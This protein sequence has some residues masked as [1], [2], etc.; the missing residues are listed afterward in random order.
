[1]Q[2]GMIWLLR[3]KEISKGFQQPDGTTLQVLKD[4]SFD[5]GD[6]QIMGLMGANGSGKTTLL[7]VISGE[8]AADGGGI[9]V[10]G[11]AIDALAAYRRYRF[12]GRVHQESY[13]AMAADLTVAQ[14][15]AIAERRRHSLRLSAP[16]AQ[17]AVLDLA[18]YSQHIADFLTG[19]ADVPTKLLSGGQR[20]LLAIAISVLGG[21]KLLL[22]DE[23]LASLDA[24]HVDIADQVIKS[25]ADKNRMMVI[26]ASH[27]KTWVNSFCHRAICLVD[28]RNEDLLIGR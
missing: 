11:D 21:P 5:L 24:I 19:R 12:I 22:L 6:G 14:M 16:N 26:A 18:D 9:A 25:A 8:L 2:E 17:G 15:L 10:D 1:M 7:N 20:Q 4:V 3:L 28:G 23:H 13:K 27:N